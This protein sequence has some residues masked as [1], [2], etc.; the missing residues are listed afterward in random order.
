MDIS[1][2]FRIAGEQWVDADAAASILEET[3]SASY[4][5]MVG[6]VI[7]ENLHLAI[8]KAEHLVKSSD[9]YVHLVTNMVDARSKANKLKVQMEYLRMKFQEGSSKEATKRAEMRL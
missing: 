9:E 2:Q 4:S 3:K 1:E 7:E 8:N 6:K 5:K